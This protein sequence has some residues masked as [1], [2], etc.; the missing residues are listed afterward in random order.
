MQNIK[1]FCASL[2]FFVTGFAKTTDFPRLPPR[3]QPA[4]H[5]VAA[6]AAN[7]YSFFYPAA[8]QRRVQVP[9]K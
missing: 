5:P 7:A 2:V 3:N 4:Q 1:M 6:A 8:Q 9:L